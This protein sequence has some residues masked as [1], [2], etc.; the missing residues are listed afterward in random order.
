MCYNDSVKR[1]RVKAYAK[2]NLT[3]DVLGVEGGYHTLESLVATVDLYDAV[4]VRARKDDAVTVVMRGMNSEGILPEQNN[5]YLAA[6]SFVKRFQTTGVDIAIDKN[7]PIGAGLGG[8]SADAAAV[9]G[10]MAR[11]YQI[12]DFAAVKQ[13]AD[14]SGSDTG[15]QLTGGYAVLRGR[16]CDVQKIDCAR[17]LN[18]LLCLPASPIYTPQCFRRYDEIGVKLQ[19][20]TAQAVSALLSGDDGALGASLRNGLFPAARTIEPKIATAFAALQSFAP[21][22]V[23]MSGSG[24]CVY[25]L[26]ETDEFCRY[27]ASRVH[28]VGRLIHVK[29]IVPKNNFKEESDG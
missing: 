13:L 29:T 1:I 12:E 26:C 19:P 15:F 9:L 8:S 28:G 6:V 25:A 24:S 18:L 20:T 11:L 21:L 14:Q 22:G 10:A 5:A 7:I 17:R 27:L 16:G 2:I 4:T 23:N 3:L